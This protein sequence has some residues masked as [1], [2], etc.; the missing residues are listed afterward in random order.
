[1]STNTAQVVAL[2]GAVLQ[3]VVNHRGRGPLP[4][5]IGRLDHA[6]RARRAQLM[7]A[8]FAAGAAAKKQAEAAAFWRASIEL[9][10]EEA[11][12]Q[13]ELLALPALALVALVRSRAAERLQAARH[14]ADKAH[15]ALAALQPQQACS[16]A[17]PLPLG[18]V[19]PVS[20][21]TSAAADDRRSLVAEGVRS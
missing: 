13:A 21:S 1:M 3:P 18:T 2:P 5:G 10:Q 9:A 4:R 11:D 20:R 15:A 17:A 6:R 14:K 8:E 12:E 16:Q 19:G 7:A